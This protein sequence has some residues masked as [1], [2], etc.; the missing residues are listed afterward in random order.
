MLSKIILY[1]GIFKYGIWSKTA[2]HESSD[3]QLTPK[4][5][6]ELLFVF[7]LGVFL[8]TVG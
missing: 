2:L 8:L 4:V 6:L 3:K 1:C 5:R 7:V